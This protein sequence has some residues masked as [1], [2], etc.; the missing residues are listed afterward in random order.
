MTPTIVFWP[1]DVR[2]DGICYGWS[3]PLVCV[4]GVLHGT[5]VSAGSGSPW[6]RFHQRV[7]NMQLSEAQDLLQAVLSSQQ[8]QP[9]RKL[10]GMDPV[11]LGT[12]AFDGPTRRG[13]V[14][15]PSLDILQ[16]KYARYEHPLQSAVDR[17]VDQD[18]PQSHILP[19]TRVE[20]VAFLFLG[21]TTNRC[22]SRGRRK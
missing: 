19:S 5:S 20:V 22:H 7:W 18:R 14:P 6:R 21:Q 2:H 9:F 8:W 13:H 1:V 10:C 12:C 4:A 15:H 17:M 3:Q 11:I 16:L